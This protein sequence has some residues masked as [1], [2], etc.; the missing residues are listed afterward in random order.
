MKIEKKIWPEYFQAILDGRKNFELRLAD[1]NIGEG[2]ILVL[3]EWDPKK[4]EYTGRS[5]E[6]EVKYIL[7][8]KE[9]NFWPKE[10]V[11]KYGYQIIGF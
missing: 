4:K 1:F 7:K 11:D 9:T 6:K 10:E 3:Q 2:D 8:V 5:L